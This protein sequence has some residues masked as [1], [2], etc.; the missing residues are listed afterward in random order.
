M[1]DAP[2]GAAASVLDS[3]RL[4]LRYVS[5]SLRGQMQYRASFVMLSV[6]TLLV[7]VLEFFGIWVLFERFGRLRDW[8]LAEVAL[9]Y[10]IVNTAFAVAEAA[11]RGFDT[12]PAMVK[13]GEFDRVLLRPRST[14]LQ[15]AGRE[16]HAV[17]VGRFV[18]GLVILVWAA[19]ALGVA[20]TPARLGLLAAA[21][22]GGGCLFSGI[23]VL[24]A[25]MAFWTTESLEILNT[26]TYGGVETAQYPLSIYRPWFRKFFT[27][28]I[29]LACINYF[30][31]LAILGRS[32][33]YGAPGF[34][35]WAAPAVG[36]AFLV[37]A[38]VV[39]RFGVRHYRSTGS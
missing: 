10:G 31:A 27:M 18:Q 20:W 23:F 22:V 15:L 3:L 6:G 9:F 38:L 17:R 1:P 29:P 5:V 26:V 11:A 35:G 33:P 34:L 32:D 16:F 36:V 7:S 25:T 4:Y 39:W 28:V 8:S 2:L 24:Q 21:V 19:R 12:F 30:P 14:V 37:L 13:S